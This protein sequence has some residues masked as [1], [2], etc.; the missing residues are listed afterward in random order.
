MM[1]NRRGFLKRSAQVLSMAA[2]TEFSRRAV[3][4]D[5]A[6]VGDQHYQIR[7]VERTTLKL[8]FRPVPQRN[9]DRE[10]PHWRYIE[11]CEVRLSSGQTGVGETMLYYTWGAPS[12]S[13]VQRVVGQSAFDMMWDD[14]LG[15]GLQMA[16]F[17][18]VGRTAGIP[19]HSLLGR[20]VHDTTPLSWWNIDTSAEDMAMECQEALKLGY[21]SYKTKGRPWFDVFQQLETATVN[22]PADFKIDMDFNETLRDYKRG[23]GILRQLGRYPQVDIFESPIPQMDMKGNRQIVDS[24]HVNVAMHYGIPEPRKVVETGC[25]DGFV[26][27]S[28]ANSLMATGRFCDEMEMPFWLQLVGA[29]LTAAFSLHFGGALK[30]ARWPAVNCHQLFEQDLLMQ[31]I[32]LDKGFATVP[33]DPGIGYKINRDLVEKLKVERPASRPEPERLIETTWPDGQTMYTANDGTINF[34]LNAANEER[35]PFYKAGADTKLI[36]NDGTEHWRKLY[37]RARAEGPI[38][39]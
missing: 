18:A 29:G 19:V 16:M 24:T 25:C 9:M 35:Y 6:A 13:D 33:D 12:D 5:G 11:L 36:P 17:D 37:A 14:T 23:R 39:V 2:L 26:V 8:E 10:I 4:A 30:Q 3:F 15:A 31:P 34:M 32:T 22:L 21:R 1:T 28:G 20:K 27:G 38:E 7:S